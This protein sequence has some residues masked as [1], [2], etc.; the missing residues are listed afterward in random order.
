MLS[1]QTKSYTYTTD[2]ILH[3]MIKILIFLSLMMCGV[4]AFAESP[5]VTK[6]APWKISTP[7]E[8][9]IGIASKHLSEFNLNPENFNFEYI[10]LWA[11]ES[12]WTNQTDA[13]DTFLLN[14]YTNN[15]VISSIETSWTNALPLVSIAL[16]GRKVYDYALSKGIVPIEVDLE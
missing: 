15:S 4:I 12:I 16:T 3:E 1:L 2:L 9:L 13:I 7:S 11:E 10:L 6:E 8:N 5:T 14:L